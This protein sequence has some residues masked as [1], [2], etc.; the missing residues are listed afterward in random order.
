VTVIDYYSRYLLACHFTPSY[1]AADVVMA[2]DTARAEAERLH[3]PLTKTSR[4]PATGDAFEP[5][6][7]G[8]P[9]AFG[10]AVRTSPHPNG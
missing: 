8:E 5:L 6:W 3:G 4:E 1:R 7:P 10:H 2:L 9:N